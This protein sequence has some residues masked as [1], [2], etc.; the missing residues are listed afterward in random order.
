MIKAVVFDL[1]DTL[2]M[3]CEY[4]MHALANV[5]QFISDE[6]KIRNA[7]SKLTALYAVD[8]KHVFDRIISQENLHD[9]QALNK[10]IKAYKNAE[11]KHLTANVG[12]IELLNLLHEKSIK[13]GIITDGDIAIQNMKIE[14]LGI[15][16]WFDE[17]IVT[18]SLGGI[19]CRKPNPEAFLLM[20]KALG[21][22]VDEMIYVG[23]N[24]EKDFVVS[25][26][27][28]ITTIQYDN[29]GIYSQSAY[30]KNILP[31][32]KINDMKNIME[33]ICRG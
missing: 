15:R 4:V 3:E 31:K 17:V 33:I 11:I 28:P 29:G 9:P 16:R 13:L 19:A 12:V 8:R 6:Y 5:A 14:A 23:D 18:D 10:M 22:Q 7:Y 26:T 24:P 2:Y 21:V 32:V 20:A 30:S 27:L 1:D 25:E